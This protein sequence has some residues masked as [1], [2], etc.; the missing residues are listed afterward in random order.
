[1]EREPLRPSTQ[2]S[3][4]EQVH[5]VLKAGEQAQQNATRELGELSDDTTQSVSGMARQVTDKAKD[6]TGNITDKASEIGDQ[7]SDKA[8][9]AMSATGAKMETL[10]QT[11]R[12]NAPAGKVGEYA[13]TAA[14]ALERGGNYLQASDL[15]D[16]QGDIEQII[17]R[18]PVESLLVGLGVGFLLARA[19][20]R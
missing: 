18:R 9:A 20:R 19:L 1:M 3:V 11:V 17:R 13:T 5:R 8:D 15:S 2:P 10:A 6:I 7:A 4:E 14:N 16:V 12:Q